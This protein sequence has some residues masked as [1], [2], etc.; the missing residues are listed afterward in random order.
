M[1]VYLNGVFRSVLEEV[2]AAQSKEA[3]LVCYLQPY[4]PTAMKELQKHPPTVGT[5]VPLLMSV[6]DSLGL[7]SYQADIVGWQDKRE[8]SEVQIQSLNAHFA[9]HQPNEGQVHLGVQGAAS[10]VNLIAVRNVRPI[11]EA[12]AVSCLTKLSDG[13]PLQKRSR[14]GGWSYVMEPPAWLGSQETRVLE[15]VQRDFRDATARSL[16]DDAELRRKRLAVAPALPS[17]IQVVS[18]AFRRNPDVTAEVLLRAN[19]TC[20]GCSQ[21]APFLRAKD[22]SPYLEVHHIVMLSHG[23]EDTVDNA[24]ALCPNCHRRFHFGQQVVIG[25]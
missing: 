19:G 7:V 16:N 15:Q 12:Y 22:G 9:V 1:A 8:L 10:S 4:K 3:S 2:I 24:K 18:R 17:T 23:G 6:T 25:G 21:P 11:A 5:S 14:A 13:T 20:E